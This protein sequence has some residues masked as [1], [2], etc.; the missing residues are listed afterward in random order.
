MNNND[1]SSVNAQLNASLNAPSIAKEYVVEKAPESSCKDASFQVGW[2]NNEFYLNSCRLHIR[3][4]IIDDTIQIVISESL[5][6]DVLDVSQFSFIAGKLCL[7]KMYTTLRL[8]TCS[9][10]MV[11]D[12][13]TTVAKC[14][15][16]IQTGDWCHISKSAGWNPF[17]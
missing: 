1:T 6:N 2:S 14:K 11:R 13:Y 5:H 16:W 17:Q 4:S 10:H 3:R 8:S 15:P 9:P 7:P 12:V